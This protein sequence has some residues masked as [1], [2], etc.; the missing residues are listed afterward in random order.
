MASRN[1][2]GT[3]AR[4][5]AVMNTPSALHVAALRQCLHTLEAELGVVEGWGATLAEHLPG[6]ARLLVAGNGGS[7][8]Q[9]QH[10]T[11]E[12]V[13]RFGMDRPPFSAIALH[14]DTSSLTAI[15]NDYGFEE[16]FARQISAHGRRGDFLLTLS[17]SGSSPNLVAALGAAQ[18]AGVRAW[19]LTG[20][21]PNRMMDVADH[22]V[23]IRSHDTTILQEIHLVAIHV[24]CASFE[25]ALSAAS[26]GQREI[27]GL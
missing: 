9:A 26:N 14:A 19:A 18:S 21:G 6:G 13:G 5:G 24:L 11:A 25:E 15:G 16:I 7:A 20:A 4:G 8:A 17:T 3:R 10:L 23:A 27:L 12:I 22:A 2:S 1:E